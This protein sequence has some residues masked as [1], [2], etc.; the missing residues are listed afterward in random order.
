MYRLPIQRSQLLVA[1]RVWR[2]VPIRSRAARADAGKPQA[3]GHPAADPPDAKEEQTMTYLNPEQSQE[4]RGDRMDCA[5]DMFPDAA[6]LAK[7]GG[8]VLVK[9]TD[10]HYQ[11][12]PR[13]DSWIIN[14]YPSNRRIYSPPDRR[15]P[16]L[17]LRSEWDLIDVVIAAVDAHLK[18]R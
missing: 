9:H 17:Q 10:V 12:R 5:A 18:I 7:D 15:G 14:I 3:A 6:Q 11:I 1:L 2:R 16:Y 8:L 13:D 4:K